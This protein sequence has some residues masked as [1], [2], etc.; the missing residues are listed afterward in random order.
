MC[1]GVLHFY[2]LTNRNRRSSLFPELSIDHLLNHYVLGLDVPMDDAQTVKVFD[3]FTQLS[4]D[5][6]NCSLTEFFLFFDDLVQL[7]L[8]SQFEYQ[9]DVV[10][11]IEEA[12][13]PDDV[14]VI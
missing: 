2:K 12:V 10:L 11:V 13:K 6:R 5:E 7:S 9:V 4:D 14:W 8:G 1:F 3:C